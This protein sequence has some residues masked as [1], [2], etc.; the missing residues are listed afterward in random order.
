MSESDN[1]CNLQTTLEIKVSNC[2][3]TADQVELAFGRSYVNVIAEGGLGIYSSCSSKFVTI[4]VAVE[5]TAVLVFFVTRQTL[6]AFS[7]TRRDRQNVQFNHRITVTTDA[8][9][10]MLMICPNTG[11]SSTDSGAD[12][13]SSNIAPRVNVQMCIEKVVQQTMNS[14]FG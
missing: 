7:T 1:C 11:T 9:N 10:C 8:G 13:N 14:N 2:A 12:S 6:L 5:W 4:R 3:A